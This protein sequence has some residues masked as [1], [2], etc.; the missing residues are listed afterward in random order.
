[1][2]ELCGIIILIIQDF[3]MQHPDFKFFRAV[4]MMIGAVIGVGVFGIPYAISQ[5][6]VVIGLIELLI[7]AVVITIMQFMVAEL[8]LQTE[9]SHRLVGYV[10][11]YLGQKWRMIALFAMAAT[12]WGSMLAYMIVGGHFLFLLFS[13][14][15]GGSEIV[16][17]Y[18]IVG[19]A[20]LLIVRGLKFASH[21]EVYVVIALLF[22][23][24]FVF[25]LAIPHVQLAYFV[26][27]HIAKWFL[28]Y[29]VI[30]FALAGTGIVPEMKAVL[31][32][33]AK[34]KLGWSILIAMTI[35]TI[36]YSFFALTVIGVTGSNTT[37][38]AFDGLIPILGN[39]FGMI[40]VILGSLS[41]VSIFM[42]IGLELVNMFHFDFHLKRQTALITVL[43]V[44]TLLYTIGLR[45]FVSLI[46]FVGSVFGGL[47]GL[48]IVKSYV[49]MKKH[50]LCQTHDCLNLPSIISWSVG[51]VFF[52][53]IIFSFFKYLL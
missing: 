51:C 26:E 43:I 8:A 5:S 41:I 31:G 15:I 45:D 50:Q 20:G 10:G 16:Y 23:F 25:V 11:K 46:G 2:G 29:G 13:P 39:S 18:L 24:I 30:L 17:A 19:L 33:Q 1:M 22:L 53:G 4:G 9:G 49:R 32:T 42:V 34:N 21:L 47:L 3:F 40:A 35:V 48:L 14:L 37:E 27:T 12:I 6:G 38:A 7:I 28:P 52:G 44:P 36:L